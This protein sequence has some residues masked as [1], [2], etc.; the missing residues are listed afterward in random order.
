ML[1]DEKRAKGAQEMP[2]DGP[3]DKAGKLALTAGEV[4][5][6]LDG[7]FPERHES[8]PPIHIEMLEPGAARLRMEFRKKLLRPGGTISGPTMFMLADYG[9]YVAILGLTGPVELAV[10]TNLSINFLRQPAQR[11]LVAEVRLQKLGRRLAVGEVALRSQAME[12]MV[13]HATGT[14]SIPPPDKR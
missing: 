9:I 11:D 5:A 2:Q 13:A 8:W 10:T 6:F 4:T 12:E 3:P 14:Y 1:G 7:V